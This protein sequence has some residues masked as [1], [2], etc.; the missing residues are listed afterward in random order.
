VKASN[1]FI[2]SVFITHSAF[3][4]LFCLDGCIYF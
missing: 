4:S 2:A 3:Y 1:R